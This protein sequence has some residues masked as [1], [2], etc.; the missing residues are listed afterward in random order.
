MAVSRSRVESVTQEKQ[1]MN[2]E[3][4]WLWPLERWLPF[5]AGRRRWRI[6]PYL[7][8]RALARVALSTHIPIVWVLLLLC[9]FLSSGCCCAHSYGLVWYVS[10]SVWFFS[11]ELTTIHEYLTQ[12][13][14]SRLSVSMLQ[15]PSLL[16]THSLN[17]DGCVF[18][19]RL[20][21]VVS[22]NLIATKYDCYATLV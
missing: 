6:F 13:V 14:L 15:N 20:R 12:Y 21:S 7:Q 3:S 8:L 4:E 10:Q 1:S 9:T 2:Q 19:N 22:R 18:N 17:G 5:I 16:L 11:N